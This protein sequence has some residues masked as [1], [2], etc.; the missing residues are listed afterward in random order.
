MDLDIPKIRKIF[1]FDVPVHELGSASPKR[2][3]QLAS[4]GRA[5]VYCTTYS[6]FPREQMIKEL[7]MIDPQLV[8]CDEAHLL[9]GRSATSKRWRHLMERTHAMFVGLSGTMA[10]KSI[11][12]YW[13]L[14]V[15]ALRDK[16]PLP[17]VHITAEFWAQVLDSASGGPAPSLDLLQSLEPLRQWAMKQIREGRIDPSEIGG[18]LTPDEHGLRRAYRV[19]RDTAPGVTSVS[20]NEI[21]TTLLIAN[22]PCFEE[23]SYVAAPNPGPTTDNSPHDS[24]SVGVN[25][26]SCAGYVGVESR[27]NQ[28]SDQEAF[29]QL[30]FRIESNLEETMPRPLPEDFCPREEFSARA[31]FEKMICLLWCVRERWRTPNGDEIDYAIHTWRW[32]Y[33]ISAGF[34]NELVWPTVAEVA[35]KNSVTEPE[36]EVL[37]GRSKAF[38]ETQQRYTRE[39]RAFLNDE[40]IPGLDTPFLV[41]GA[42]ARGRNDLLPKALYDKWLK[43]KGA[44]FDQRIERVSRVARVC[45]WKIRAAVRWA[46]EIESELGPQVGGLVWAW[47]NEVM[48][49]AYELF[50]SEFGEAKVLFCP[51]GRAA[52]RR[53]Q[54][55]SAADR[56]TIA[57]I[58][59]H[60]EGKDLFH[61][62]EQ[63][64]LQ[65]P[66]GATVTEQVLGRTHRP[67]QEADE[68]EVRTFNTLEFDHMNYSACLHDSLW[69]NQAESLQKIIHADYDP[70]PKL[71]PAKFLEERGF[72]LE[73]KDQDKALKLVFGGET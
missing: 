25:N 69:L 39:L 48:N 54:E 62:Q 47:N 68:L 4:S 46:R 64:F 33:E 26:S 7:E 5:G 42:L 71:Y 53:I 15:V 67:G 21:G 35:A 52:D 8:V 56:W 34:Y 3:L 2:R 23:A 9:T 22:R 24:L 19:R 27:K 60:G 65:F 38:H 61:Y 44:D 59:G 70:Q 20:E 66:R 28:G 32:Q 1:G 49:W 50:V 36:A 17:L 6:L 43:M 45:D 12:N 31:P 72:A 37:L 11:M 41:A 51:A 55:K 57:S 40:H 14:V 16:A 29:D 30:V 73:S 18:P 13:P 58:A 63:C 10:K